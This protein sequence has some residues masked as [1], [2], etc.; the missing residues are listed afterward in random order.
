MPK[1]FL[2]DKMVVVGSPPAETTVK[3]DQPEIGV[4]Q[5]TK[6]SNAA[7]NSEGIDVDWKPAKFRI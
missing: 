4:E 2:I 1:L 6:C 3:I 7:L 5:H